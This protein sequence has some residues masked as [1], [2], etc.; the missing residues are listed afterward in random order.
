M[1]RSVAS[2][3]ITP[4]EAADIG[5][6]VLVHIEAITAADLSTRLARLE[7]PGL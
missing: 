4:S 1:L 2:G 7:D 5:K 6:A 3:E